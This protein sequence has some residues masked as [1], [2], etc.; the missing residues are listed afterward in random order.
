MSVSPLNVRTSQNEQANLQLRADIVARGILQNLIEMPMP[1][2]KGRYE[3]TADG[4]RLVQIHAAI[5]AKDLD[6]DFLVPLL[7]ID[8]RDDAEEASLAENF[9]RLNMNPSDE[10]I[11]F[12]HSESD[13]PNDRYSSKG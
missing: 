8:D 9:Q 12:G 2:K 7:V 4:R 1:R 5:E 3:I 13:P 6:A 11:A 10:C